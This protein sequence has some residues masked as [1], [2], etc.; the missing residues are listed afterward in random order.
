VIRAALAAGKHVLTE[1][2]L[3]VEANEAADLAAAADAAGVVNAVS[4]Q[5]YHSPGAHFVAD[6]IRKV[7]VG[8]VD[9]ASFVGGGDPLGGS[10]IPQV[11]S[12][13][14]APEAGTGVLMIMGG[15]TLA[16]LDAVAGKISEVAAVA[17][18]RH[19]TVTVAETGAPLDNRIAGQ[20]A[21][22]GQ[23]VGGALAS[24]SLHGGNA[25]GPDGFH[26]TI[27]GTE[28]TI[29][30]TAARPGQFI[31]WAD[32]RVRVANANG[33]AEEVVV[34]AGPAHNITAVYREVAQ[35]I[36]E[37]R[38]AR[39]DFHT[40]ARHQRV[41]AAVERAARTG[42]HERVDAAAAA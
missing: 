37:G 5:A 41:L 38:P 7:S 8:T 17:V 35:A 13:S 15:H 3:A 9:S 23:F 20:V 36:T 34:P 27:A 11:L 14:T 10:R 39:P 21:F 18:N 30:A 32:W 16:V 25:P 31:N 12:W 26:L 4:L 6:A 29:T 40:A 1:W 2:P 33:T 42:R 19:P 22:V 24:V 28:G